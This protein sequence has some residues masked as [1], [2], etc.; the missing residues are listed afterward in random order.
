M[1]TLAFFNGVTFLLCVYLGANYK[2]KD[3]WHFLILTCIRNDLNVFIQDGLLEK[4]YI[5]MRHFSVMNKEHLP[6]K[7][8]GWNLIPWSSKCDKE[9]LI[10]SILSFKLQLGMGERWLFNNSNLSFKA[11]KDDLTFTQTH[12]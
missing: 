7:L 1:S 8:M 6:C 5:L 10:E 4:K 9:L 12:F 3:F 2:N 11:V